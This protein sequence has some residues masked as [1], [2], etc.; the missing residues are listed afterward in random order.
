MDVSLVI[1][2]YN[3]KAL[4]LSLLR[5][6]E[7][8]SFSNFE[9]IV[10]DDGS[11][12]GTVAAVKALQPVVGYPLR[13]V[14]QK[15]EGYRLARSRNNGALAA[16]SRQLVFMDD[17]CLPGTHHV[18]SYHRSFTPNY[19]LRGDIIF[20]RAFDRPDIVLERHEADDELWGCNFSIPRDLFLQVG[21]FD[22]DFVDQAGE[23]T[24]LE[25]RL[26]RLGVGR[27]CVQEAFVYHLGH[28][29]KGGMPNNLYWT[30]KVHDPTVKRN[31][32]KTPK[33]EEHR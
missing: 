5:K 4:L 11:S 28:H 17:D 15:H 6:L 18:Y 10:A 19:V 20:V 16:N 9:V 26:S 23:D 32:S 13:V 3:R 31:V 1:P 29:R 14:T 12:D 30:V 25:L 2:T 24:D 21:G 7:E 8:Q 22:E 27:I 33:L